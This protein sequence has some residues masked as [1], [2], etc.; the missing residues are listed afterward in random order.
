M[1]AFDRAIELTIDAPAAG[2]RMIARLD[3]QIVFVAGAI[4]GERVRARIERRQRQMLWA[5]TIDVIEPSADRRDPSG[6]PACGGLAFA[7]IQPARQRSLK[8]EIVADAFRRIA[9]QPLDRLPEV[10]ISPERG[11]RLRARLHVREARAGFFLEGS[12]TLCDPAATGQLLPESLQATERVLGALGPRAR[13]VSAVVIAENV[14]STSRVLHVEPHEGRRLDTDVAIEMPGDVTGVTTWAP[15]RAIAT[16]AGDPRVHETAAAVFGEATPIAPVTA[17]TRHAPAFFQG[18]RFLLGTLLRRVLH[19]AAGDRVADFYAGVG[20]F[21]VALAARGSQVV[22]VEGDSMSAA[23]LRANVSAWAGR[24][25][26]R[27]MAV[28]AASPAALGLSAGAF[29]VVVVDP[30][31]TGMTPEAL[32]RVMECAPRRV[33]YVSCDPPTLARDAAKLAASGFQLAG[34][35]AFDLFPNTAHVETL[36]VFDRR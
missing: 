26:A 27:E 34:L 9:R 17:W 14:A 10:A 8:A 23:D 20:L 30:P 22:A 29:D 19:E 3:G 21:S 6:D 16:I 35:E 33:V 25:D 36:A 4:P 28:E 31:R 15:N 1:M 11:Y 18:N 12:H 13:D 7:H 24:I 2:G 5:S 32:S